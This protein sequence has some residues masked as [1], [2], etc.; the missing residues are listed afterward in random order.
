MSD[1]VKQQQACQQQN[2]RHAP[3]SIQSVYRALEN[4]EVG[5][6]DWRVK[7]AWRTKVAQP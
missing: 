4:I 5:V 3:L 2:L 6:G 1:T 7:S